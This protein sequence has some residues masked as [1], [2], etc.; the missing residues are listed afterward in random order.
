MP[1]ARMLIVTPLRALFGHFDRWQDFQHTVFVHSAMGTVARAWGGVRNTSGIA[2][3]SPPWAPG[4]CGE[5]QGV[6]HLG[7][8]KPQ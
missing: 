3:M 6:P 7:Q 8:A 4:G 1:D 2:E 5:T